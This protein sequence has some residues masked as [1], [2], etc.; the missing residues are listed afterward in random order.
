MSTQW[1]FLAR[2][3]SPF[4]PLPE[5][6]PE[7]V[8]FDNSPKIMA[9]TG[10]RVSM[11]KVFR[12]DDWIILLAT[13]MCAAIFACFKLRFNQG[14]GKYA[15]LIIM[16]P[17]KW[18]AFT[19]FQ[20]GASLLFIAGVAAIKISIAFN[21]L[22]VTKQSAYAKIIYM[23]IVFTV[24]LSLVDDFG[25]FKQFLTQ[26]SIAG[27]WDNTVRPPPL[28]TGTGKCYSNEVFLNLGLMNSS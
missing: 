21:L 14:L 9:I 19:K 17:S 16:D 1:E 15:I 26:G 3:Q 2:R 12:P 6:T 23:V 7:Y 20:H 28:G 25:R 24:I 8:A 11:I 27:A 5:L 13:A 18:R 10:I 22:Q 4:G